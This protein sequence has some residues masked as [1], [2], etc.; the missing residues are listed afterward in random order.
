MSLNCASMNGTN[1]QCTI[2]WNSGCHT[3]TQ[4]NILIN[5]RNVMI[6]KRNQ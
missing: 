2:K 4:A 5:V 6:H 3:G 1:L